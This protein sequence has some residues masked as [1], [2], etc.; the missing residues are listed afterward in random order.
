MGFKIGA[1]SARAR[2]CARPGD[3]ADDT[4]LRAELLFHVQ[5]ALTFWYIFL[6]PLIAYLVIWVCPITS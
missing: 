5:V 6:S 4:H 2:L 3:T 1:C